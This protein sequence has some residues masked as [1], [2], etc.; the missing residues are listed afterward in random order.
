MMADTGVH[1]IEPLDPLGGVSVAGAKKRVGHKVALMGGLNTLTLARA[2]PEEVQAEAIQKCR[3]G[4]PYGYVLAGG[5][6]VP[7]DT[8]MANL[9]ALVEVATKSL[10]K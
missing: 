6:M 5:D 9:R 10:W 1:V 8:S 3:K 4:G 7:P 2:A